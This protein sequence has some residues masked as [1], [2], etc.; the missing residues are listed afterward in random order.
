MRKILTAG[1]VIA[2]CVLSSVLMT[3]VLLFAAEQ[4]STQTTLLV[5]IQPV[6]LIVVD[7][8]ASIVEIYSNTTNDI[9][10][11]VTLNTPDGMQL[12]YSETIAQEYQN[13]KSSVSFARAGLVY[14]RDTRP[15]QSVLKKVTGSTLNWFWF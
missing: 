2:L 9:R 14:Q 13:L 7:Q 5:T 11:I 4:R 10:P 8:N 3:N 15:V 1:G 6:R 12:P